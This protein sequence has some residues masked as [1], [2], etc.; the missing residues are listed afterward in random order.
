L[1]IPKRTIIAGKL[2]ID[3][4]LDYVKIEKV[5]LHAYHMEFLREL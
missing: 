2:V 5:T 4:I 1:D 3:H